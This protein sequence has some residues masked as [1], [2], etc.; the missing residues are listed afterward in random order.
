[1]PFYQGT[2]ALTIPLSMIAGIGFGVAISLV[3]FLARRKEDKW[4]RIIVIILISVIVV[5]SSIICGDGVYFIALV[6]ETIDDPDE[7]I[8]GIASFAICLSVEGLSHVARWAIS[9]KKKSLCMQIFVRLPL[10][11]IDPECRRV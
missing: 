5:F 11:N 4:F 2:N 6:W 10:E 7:S 1:M 9:R 3:V 8:W